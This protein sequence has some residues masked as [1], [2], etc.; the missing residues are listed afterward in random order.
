MAFTAAE[1]DSIANAALDFYVNRGETFKQSIQDRPML[2]ALEPND[3][4]F[5][6]GKENISVGV[7]GVYGAGGTNDALKGFTHDDAVNFYTPT[8]IQRANYPWRE[9]HIGI[10]LTHTELKIDGMSVVDTD[11]DKTRLHPTRDETVLVGLFQ[12]KL[13]D[14]A[15]QYA[16]SMNTLVWGDGTGDA[17]AL[18][19]IRSM[20]LDN[21]LAGTV[22]GLDASLS[23]NDFWRNRARTAAYATAHGSSS[24]PHGGGA[25]TSSPTSG[26]A[27]AQVLQ[28][29][30]RQ[31]RRFGGAK[32][33]A[34]C[35]GSDWIDALEVE[36]RANGYYSD[37]GFTGRQDAGMGDLYF[38]G[39]KIVYD[40]TLDDLGLAKRAYVLDL[41][42]IRRYWMT[43]ERKRMITPA[44]PH[45]KFVLYR[46]ITDTGQMI[47]TR[48]N[49]SLV[50]DIT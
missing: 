35:A 27:L 29:E 41:E 28:Q 6:G 16:R 9:M 30:W 42:H 32:R 33:V 45:D 19:G 8:N 20:V 15:E 22:G 43:G 40:P 18:A 12:E 4:T 21:P 39:Q 11:G 14:F 31:L 23:A 7:K 34:F 37:R 48:R 44:R 2:A 49:S 26:G 36:M 24:G 50:I 46:S 17:K 3:K 25:V 47:C 10:T 1:L 38:K 13:D 5:P